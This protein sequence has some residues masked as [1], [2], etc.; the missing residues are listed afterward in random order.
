MLHS[1]L[2]AIHDAVHGA[3][4]VTK[5]GGDDFQKAVDMIVS[6]ADFRRL[7]RI[8]Q[9]GFVSANHI[10]AA[11]DR[12]AHSLGSM[13]MMWHLLNRLRE[14]RRLKGPGF[15]ILGDVRTTFNAFA[16]LEDGP[17]ADTLAEHLMLAALIQDIGELPYHLA[18][19]RLPASPRLRA[20]VLAHAPTAPVNQLEPK[21][22]FALAWLHRT[23]NARFLSHY[24]LEFL[25]ALLAGLNPEAL[26]G[27]RAVRHMLDGAVDAD[28][29]DYVYRDAFHVLGIRRDTSDLIASLD[30][31]DQNGPVFSNAGPISDFL[32]LRATLW[33]TVYLSPPNRFRVTLLRAVMSDLAG[34]GTSNS[35]FAPLREE[36][37]DY[38][39]FS[40]LDDGSVEAVINAARTG[41]EI[42]VGPKAEHALTVLQNATPRYE[43]HWLPEPKANGPESR[44]VD[45]GPQ[46]LPPEL[47]VDTYF[48]Y[49][50]HR[51]YDANSIR[52]DM[53]PY[54]YMGQV[55]GLEHCSGPFNH[56]LGDCASGLPMP[57]CIAVFRPTIRSGAGWRGIDAG[58]ESGSLYYRLRREGLV[59][60]LPFSGDTRKMTDFK[61]PDIFISFAFEDLVEVRE[62]AS[63]LKHR[64]RRY[65]CIQGAF[66]GLGATT[67]ENS[68]QA[69]REAGAVLLVYSRS[70]TSKFATKLNGGNIAAEVFE[71]IDRVRDG[72]KII[73]VTLEDY[74]GSV[75]EA[76]PWRHLGYDDGSVPMIGGNLTGALP[77]RVD[78][79]LEEALKRIDSGGDQ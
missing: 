11:H 18:L 2:H 52:V 62:I 55:V 43:F 22:V 31:Y 65:Y 56:L 9:L 6:S 15:D 58:I 68:K 40:K 3:I 35:P 72:L 45:D 50:G 70:Y 25:T 34:V 24:D 49:Q 16:D 13:Y 66:D 33:S 32:A 44:K 4:D 37:L 47:F 73:P 29:L 75:A 60:V 17:L 48:E 69:V 71:M 23:E 57:D 77:D 20:S 59:D 14:G 64:R 7:K 30:Y 76:L 79:A 51:L 63:R 28:R 39:D 38:D 74:D 5:L 36:G 26:P 78:Q 8:K 10:S 41:G 53:A 54:R 19:A 21:T 46:E 42:K 61:G 67:L 1:G 27:V 12:Y